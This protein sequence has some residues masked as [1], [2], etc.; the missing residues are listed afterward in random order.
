MEIPEYLPEEAMRYIDKLGNTDED[1]RIS[2]WDL[3]IKG[4]PGYIRFCAIAEYLNTMLPGYIWIVN[5]VFLT[6]M[7]ENQSDFKRVNL[8]FHVGHFVRRFDG[9]EYPEL[10]RPITE[11]E[12]EL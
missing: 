10:E 9:H 5:P 7:S 2:L 3:G 6:V 4:V 8:P 11:E 12:H 1:I